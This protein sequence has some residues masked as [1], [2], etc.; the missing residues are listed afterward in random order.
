L[1]VGFVWGEAA[2]E[3]LFHPDET[4]TTAVRS[5][6]ERFTEFGS[7]RRV[8]LWL[9]SEAPSFPLQDGPHGRIRWVV[10]TY[11]AI[12]H[13]LTNPV[14]AGAYAYG[15]SR[16]ERYVDEQGVVKKRMRHLPIDQWS[17][18]IP[19]H[20]VGFIDWPT[21]EANQKRLDTNTRPG[22]HRMGGIVREGSALLQ[23][24]GVCGHCGRRKRIS[25]AF[26]AAGWR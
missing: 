15:K 21:F 14:Y 7:A 13:I 1:P 10:P 16:R 6:F 24:I 8:W 2:G 25:Q 9:R 26:R 11:T 5:V 19:E 4:V 20:H 17:V 12:H 22:P 3:V 23:G 18:L